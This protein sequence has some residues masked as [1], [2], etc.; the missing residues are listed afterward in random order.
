MRALATDAPV[1]IDRAAV[2]RL[3][4][5]RDAVTAVREVYAAA[6]EP[7]MSPTRSVARGGGSRLRAMAAVLPDGG[8]MGAKL[9]VQPRAAGTSYLIALFSQDNGR[10]LAL[11]DGSAITP[12]RTAA[13][14]AVAVDALH[15]VGGLRLGVLGSGAIAREHVRALACVRPIE[16]LRVYSPNPEH[17]RAFAAEMGE[18]LGV[19][20]AAAGSARELVEGSATIVAAARARLEEPVLDGTWLG[21]GSLVLSIGSTLPEQREL[22]VASL[23]R[24]ELIVADDRSEVLETSGDCIAAAREGVELAGKTVE[25]SAAVRDSSYRQLVREGITIFKSV[26]S[27]L[28][29]LALALLVFERGHDAAEPLALALARKES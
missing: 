16:S 22:D 1:Y 28:Q 23:E 13:T 9:V 5:C 10:L 3:V 12:L 18:S 11:L 26:G 24:A 17:C 19:P 2:E 14:S 25:L 27:A 15:G 4:S 8:V 21:P 7:G 20:H 6:L 29:D